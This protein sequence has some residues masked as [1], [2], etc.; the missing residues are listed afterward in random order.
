MKKNKKITK[1]D[2]LYQ[3][4]MEELMAEIDE[5]TEDWLKKL[6]EQTTKN[7]IEM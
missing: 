2:E 1:N 5:K 3:K 6:K 7:K 4:D